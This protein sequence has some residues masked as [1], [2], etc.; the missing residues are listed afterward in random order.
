MKI[1]TILFVASL[2][3]PIASMLC[4]NSISNKEDGATVVVEMKHG[5]NGSP[6]KNGENGQ[7][8]EDGQN[9]GN[10]GNSD[11]GCGGDGGNGGDVD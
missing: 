8:G 1:S 5:K 10:G 11:W 4:A 6:G 9:G 7:N 3:F 2:A